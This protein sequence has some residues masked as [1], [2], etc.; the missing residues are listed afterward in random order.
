M[1]ANDV[2]HATNDDRPHLVTLPACKYKCLSAACL[3]RSYATCGHL[4]EFTGE[5]TVSSI[6]AGEILRVG[7]LHN[8]GG[9]EGS[10]HPLGNTYPIQKDDLWHGPLVD[11]MHSAAS[12]AGYIINYTD[13]PPWVTEQSGSASSFTNCVYA[14]GL[15][16]LD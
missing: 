16:Y 1:N 12:E 6:L 2:L 3:S 10:Y 4:D 5:P 14:V 13:V 15:G 9:W 7:I 8:T 11:L